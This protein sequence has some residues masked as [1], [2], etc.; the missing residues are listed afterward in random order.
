MLAD[1][2]VTESVAAPVPEV[3]ESVSQDC[4]L[5]AVHAGEPVPPIASEAAAFDPAVALN[6]RGEGEAVRVTSA[7]AATVR[8]TE[9]VFG[10]TLAVVVSAVRE[11][12]SLTVTIPLYDPAAIPVVFAAMFSVP[13]FVPEPGVTFSHVWF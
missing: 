7:A 6:V 12:P 8:V 5:L 10:A 1:A 13:L 9:T 2:A 11:P 4:V 3:C